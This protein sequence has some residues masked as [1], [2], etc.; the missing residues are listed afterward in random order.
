MKRSLEARL[1]RQAGRVTSADDIARERRC[2]WRRRAA[3]GAAV[4]CWLA[5]AGIDP[6]RAV[7]LRA[8]D[9]AGARLAAT[10]DATRVP[11]HPDKSPPEHCW[12]DPATAR[13]VERYSSGEL[14]EPDLAQASLAELF[15][16][17]IA[18]NAAATEDRDVCC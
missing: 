15:A 10:Q 3:I 2:R 14:R 16:W 7:M 1:D 12:L 18:R 8:A 6:A 13:L 5:Q 4:R 11:P 9:A 17:C